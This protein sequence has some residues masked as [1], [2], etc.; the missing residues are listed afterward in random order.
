[1]PAPCDI[2]ELKLDE[3]HRWVE[4]FLAGLME[5]PRELWRSLLVI[6]DEAYLFCPERGQGESVAAAAMIDLAARR[7][8]RGFY[9]VFATQRLAKLAKNATAELQ[10]VLIGRTVQ[11]VDLKRAVDALG[12]ER[13]AA[14]DLRAD[15]KLA[16]TQH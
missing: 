7:R 2:S 10:N 1:M 15:L 13:A 4:Q 6:V 12:Y 9:P 11:D 3:R 14:R 16:Q 5:A 8:K